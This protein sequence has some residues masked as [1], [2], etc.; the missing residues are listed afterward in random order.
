MYKLFLLRFRYRHCFISVTMRPSGYFI[1]S[2]LALGAI[3]FEALDPVANP[4]GQFGTNAPQNGCGPPSKWRPSDEKAS[5]FGVYRSRNK[6]KNT[7][8]KV[9]N[10]LHFIELQYVR[11]EL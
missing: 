2:H 9:N 6:D 8:S 7:Q 4:R 1:S 3:D 5:L 10:A 11:D